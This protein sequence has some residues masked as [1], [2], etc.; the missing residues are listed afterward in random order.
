MSHHDDLNPDRRRRTPPPLQHH[1]N[2]HELSGVHALKSP[3]RFTHR[4]KLWASLASQQPDAPACSL[5]H[6]Q[7]HTLNVPA[8]LSD[9][10]PA[11][12]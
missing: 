4:V 11:A 6:T 5:F 8:C 10:G 1:V 7:K 9:S 2:Q 3:L 12:A